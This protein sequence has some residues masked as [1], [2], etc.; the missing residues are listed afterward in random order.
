MA[1]GSTK[2]VVT[3]LFA[4]AG[5]AVAKFVGFLIT[6]A[7]SM[8]AESIHSVADSGNQGLLLL[9]GAR[10]QRSATAQHA[11]GYGRA[12]YFWAFVVSVVLFALGGMF[13]L[14]EGVQKLLHPH[15]VTSLGVAIG[16]LVLGLAL[17]GFALRTAM[18]EAQPLRRGRSWWR[19]VRETKVPE[20][21]VVLLED[22]GALIGL[23]LALVGV[24]LASVTGNPA[25]DAVGT[26][27][28]GALL[29]VISVVLAVEMQSMLLGES[30]DPAD[31]DVI[32]TTLSGTDGITE[33][34]D[35]RTQHLGP[36]QVLVAGQIRM[37]GSL[38]ADEV[39]AVIDGAERAVRHALSYRV[40]IFLEPD[41]AP[42]RSDDRDPSGDRA[43]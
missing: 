29:L 14:Y 4:N 30:A 10:A 19:F 39:V 27:C 21:A 23:T 31:V 32:R 5:I 35:L 34:L 36:E 37:D 26:L 11:F 2:A 42:D 15:E 40:D 41:T 28:I 9:G 8:L 17:E 12:R 1:G 20:L 6:G 3:A 22:L 24:V 38:R 16:I 43:H 7:S 13:S 18:N 33:V 25:W